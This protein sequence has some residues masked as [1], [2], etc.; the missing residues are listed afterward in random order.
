MRTLE[1][2]PNDRLFRV[3]VKT[4]G[5]GAIMIVPSG[6]VPAG[7]SGNK[8]LLENWVRDRL[9]SGQIIMTY[10]LPESSEVVV[11]F[12]QVETALVSTSID[13]LLDS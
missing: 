2:L 10:Y 4:R 13:D 1:I 11:I 12:R 3:K 9:Q 7:G 8:L 6:M 5:D